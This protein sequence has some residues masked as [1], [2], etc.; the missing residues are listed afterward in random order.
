[1]KLSNLS[2]VKAIW[3]FVTI[4][5]I[6][7]MFVPLVKMLALSF[8]V[9]DGLGLGNYTSIVMSNDFKQVML[10]SFFVATLSALSA[11]LLA[12]ILAYTVHWTNLPKGFKQVIKL[13]SLFPMLL[14]TVTYGF[15]IIYTF[16]KQGLLTQ[17][18]GFQLFESIYGF[19]GMWLGYTIYTLPIAFLLLNNTF[20]YLDKKFVIVSELMGDSHLRQFDMTVIRPLIGT[21]AAALIQCFFLAFTDFGIPAS[22]GGQYKVIATELYT[23]ILG[24]SPSFEKGAVIALFMLIPSVLSILL[25][26]YVSRFNIRY[27][28][29]ENINIPTS[30]IKDRILALL[31]SVILFSILLVFAVI[32]IIPWIKAWP[33]QME[34]S[35]ETVSN[36][37]ESTNLMRVYKNSLI[38]ALLT[39]VF[40]TLITYFSALLY[41]RSSLFKIG[42]FSI[43]SSAL[44]TNT[45]PGMVVGIAYLM[46]FSGSA[47]A[48]TIFIIVI[49]NIIHYFS[50]PYLM[51]KNAL[52]KMN[53][54]WETTAGLL[55]DSWFTALRRIVIPNS[56]FTLIEVASFYFISAMVTISAVIFISGARTMVLTTK[57]VE[58]QHFARFD[59]IFILSLMILVT[60]ICALIVFAIIRH[61]H[62]KRLYG[63]KKATNE[64][65]IAPTAA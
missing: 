33:Y 54:G 29:V 32:F 2:Q 4:L 3:L 35:T 14:P 34:F 57:I 52:S 6:A 40:G 11:T 41:E 36:V 7:F 8:N 44:V 17:I 46:I 37:L 60:N 24:A 28:S 58:L 18:L 23:Q 51:S 13:A 59:E 31:S 48:N 45:V 61:I 26:W 25:L 1:M 39:A 10:N 16:G 5:F 49:S 64:T 20:Q 47:I 43:E 42:K 9:G 65:F 55:G 21:F 63:S 53:L 22:I 19:Y 12:F 38:V 50:T 27:D 62:S 15:A 30:K 56:F